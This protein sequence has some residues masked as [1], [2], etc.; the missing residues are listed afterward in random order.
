MDIRGRICK[1]ERQ[2]PEREDSEAQAALWQARLQRAQARAGLP[3]YNE[4]DLSAAPFRAE[5]LSL[6][7][8][9]DRA[10]LRARD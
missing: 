5:K 8:L 6:A 10:I 1:L 9:L 2:G 3:P 7:D 4:E